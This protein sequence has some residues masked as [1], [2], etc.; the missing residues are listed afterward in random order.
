MTGVAASSGCHMFRNYWVPRALSGSSWGAVGASGQKSVTHSVLFLTENRQNNHQTLLLSQ[1]REVKDGYMI[2]SFFLSQNQP[3]SL[4][5]SLC[6]GVSW[7]LRVASSL[8][9]KRDDIKFFPS[10]LL[11]LQW[12]G[13][14]VAQTALSEHLLSPEHQL[15]PG[16]ISSALWGMMFILE[17]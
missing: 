9:L 7:L 4:S 16:I 6:S 15:G 1:L 14:E 3:C 5:V 13:S 11:L 8:R 17:K 10:T 12:M 2:T